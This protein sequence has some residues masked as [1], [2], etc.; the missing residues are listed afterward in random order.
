M[1]KKIKLLWKAPNVSIAQ[2]GPRY[3]EYVNREGKT[4]FYAPQ[5]DDQGNIVYELDEEYG[6]RLLAG[7]AD[8]FFLLSPSE[9]IIK[10]RRAD[11]MGSEYVKI[12][13]LATAP[14]FVAP[15]ATPAT[16]QEAATV[17]ETSAEG[18]DGAPIAVEAALASA[19]AKKGKPD[20]KGNRPKATA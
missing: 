6:R 2:R 13:G 15:A 9:L 5:M 19:E 11:Q 8:R 16:V 14:A 1:S 4:E 20:E 7:Q 17:V 12:K 10:R 18:S 3:L